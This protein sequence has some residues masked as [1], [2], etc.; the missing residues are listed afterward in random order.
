MPGCGNRLNG[1]TLFVGNSSRNYTVCYQDTT[2]AHY[3]PGDVIDGSCNT[4][5]PILGD[6]VKIMINNFKPLTLCEV[7]IF[8]CTP[9]TYGLDCGER[10]GN[11]A[12]EPSVCDTTSG[13]CPQRTPRCMLGYRTEKCDEVCTPGTYGLDCGKRCGNCAEGPSVCDTTSGHCPQRT[14][15][16]MLGYR[17]EKCDEEAKASAEGGVNP[18]YIGGGV[19]AAV[20][21][22]IIVAV[23]VII[24]FRRRRKAHCKYD[25][26]EEI[27]VDRQPQNNI[28]FQED[29]DDQEDDPQGD[30]NPYVNADVVPTEVSVSEFPDYG[31]RK[32]AAKG[33]KKEFEK[34]PTGLHAK[35]DAADKP[36]NKAKS[37][38]RSLVAYDHS[39]VLLS[40][41]DGQ[42]TD[43]IN[44]CYINGYN[45]PKKYI[46]SQGPN[47]V[48]LHD[49]L[50]MIWEQKSGKIIMVTNLMETTKTKCCQYWPDEGSESF[51]LITVTLLNEEFY[52]EFTVRTLLLTH[53][54]TKTESHTVKQFHFTAWPD[55]GAPAQP[56]GLLDF[57][58]KVNAYQTQ[59]NGPIV[60]HCSAGVGR[61]GTYI[62]L[63]YLISQ[64]QDEGVVD[65][66]ACVRQ[67]REQRVNMVQA[68]VN[69]AFYKPRSPMADQSRLLQMRFST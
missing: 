12:E 69:M 22:I 19:A 7:Q 52:G 17:T 10:C 28:A 44:A 64:A 31:A 40:V 8:V 62:A 55:H 53:N 24:I 43:Y 6:T 18:A 36:E 41:T 50:R 58:D 66:P 56:T 51:G 38:Y 32:K 2:T 46:A 4:S 25:D 45:E 60:V 67:L 59:L 29:S 26:R 1:F 13:H 16:C 35:H 68:L 54:Q 33:F 11:C 3:G 65:V 57:R 34:F 63:D 27:E 39:R 49:F 5:S 20:V 14:P 47:D 42:A 61:T 15:R 37:R 21:L 23:V 9:G 48:I 30:V